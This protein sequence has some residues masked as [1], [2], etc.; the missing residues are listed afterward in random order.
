[1]INHNKTVI[2]YKWKIVTDIVGQPVVPIFKDKAV[3]EYSCTAWS[4]R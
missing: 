3:Q 1:M 4:W 2:P